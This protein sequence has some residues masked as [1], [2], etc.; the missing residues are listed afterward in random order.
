[1][2]LMYSALKDYESAP[3]Y[4][5]LNI[6]QKM[7]FKERDFIASTYYN[8]A[9]LYREKSDYKNAL[10]YYIKSM[11]TRKNHLKVIM[12]SGFQC[13]AK[14]AICLDVWEMKKGYGVF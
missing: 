10:K 14:L 1:M 5:V 4:Y 3:E 8:I 7:L 11:K 13:I 12:A 9:E 2:G 6:S